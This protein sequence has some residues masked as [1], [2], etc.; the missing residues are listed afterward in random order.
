MAEIRFQTGDTFGA[1]AVYVREI[2]VAP[3]VRAVLRNTVGVVG[4]CVRGPVGR[5]V[6]CSSFGR[7]MAV[8][9][10]RDYGAGGALIGHVW[11]FF[12]GNRLGRVLV[13]RA[14][15]AA[16][17][18]ASFTWESVAAGG[19]VTTIQISA[20][21]PGLWGND[22]QFKITAASDA[23]AGHFNLTIRY[24]GKDYVLQN[25]DTSGSND[26]LALKVAAAFGD[27][28][29]ALVVVTKLSST[30]PVNTAAGV[31]GADTA[32]FVNLGETAPAFTSVAGTDG[33]I[34]DSDYTGTGKGMEIINVAKGVGI[35]LVAGRS[36]TAV[37]TKAFALAQV[38]S[39]RLWLTT[40]DAASTAGTAA[41]AEAATFRHGRFNMTAGYWYMLDPDT[42]EEMEREPHDLLAGVLSQT[43]PKVHPSVVDNAVY[44]TFVRRLYAEVSPDQADA[45]DS[46]VD[47]GV[48]FLSSDVDDFGNVVYGFGNAITTSL[49]DN[50]RQINGR[51]SRDYVIRALSNRC[52]PDLYRGNTAARRE[53][54]KGACSAWLRERALAGEYVASDEDGNP[55]FTYVNDGTVNE[56]SAVDAGEQREFVRVKMLA[57]ALYMQLRVEAATDVKFSEV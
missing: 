42:G 33:S 8:F 5:G 56:Q 15:A 37:K 47:G 17:V 30:R 31:D 48:T 12:Q 44:F 49:T 39:E 25:C 26:N 14:A 38:A 18:T 3:E 41:L 45:F 46:R 2:A 23:V 11:R 19:G 9:G 24:L 16:A 1:P 54:R 27:T 35:C 29:A 13:V 57:D 52:K 22:V 51:R 34:A 6:L 20:A 7:F 10:A 28:D 32:G 55:L 43:E 50:A 21:N 53:A 4:Q 40:T 36:N